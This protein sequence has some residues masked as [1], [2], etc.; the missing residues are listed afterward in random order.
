MGVVPTG[1]VSLRE[2]ADRLE[3]TVAG[4]MV[5]QHRFAFDRRLGVFE[6]DGRKV[7]ALSQIGG[8]DVLATATG[9]GGFSFMLVIVHVGGSET[10]YLS[11][12]KAAV[13][14]LAA[15]IAR[16]LGPG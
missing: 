14:E 8:V 15:S 2:D 12:D 3:L 4:V 10:L 6:R 16:F 7:C 9:P 13:V 5:G 11:D 1:Q